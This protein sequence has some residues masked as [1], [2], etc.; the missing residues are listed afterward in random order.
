VNTA[1]RVDAPV[2]KQQL[3]ELRSD[4]ADQIGRDKRFIGHCYLCG[5][6]VSPSR[7]VCRA[8]TWAIEGDRR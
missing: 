3:E 7:L 8:H 6:P 4:V 2:V 1:R 5:A